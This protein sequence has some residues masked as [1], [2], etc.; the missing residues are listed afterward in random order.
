MSKTRRNII[1]TVVITDQFNNARHFFVISLKPKPQ[2][3]T[4]RHKY[5]LIT[6]KAQIRPNYS[7]S[8]RSVT[9]KILGTKIEN[10]A[11]K[12]KFDGKFDL[13]TQISDQFRIKFVPSFF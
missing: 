1:K 4:A 2:K 11:P 3:I 5:D 12:L 13:K 10:L 7:H 9:K 6:R 8:W